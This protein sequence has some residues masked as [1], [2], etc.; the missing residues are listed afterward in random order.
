MKYSSKEKIARYF[1]LFILFVE[2]DI[3]ILILFELSYSFRP[4]VYNTGRILIVLYILDLTVQFLLNPR[5][6]SY[7]L[8]YWHQYASLFSLILL[9][10]RFSAVPESN[11]FLFLYSRLFLGCVEVIIFIKFITRLE[12]IREIWGSFKVNPAQAIIMSFASII[13]LGSFLLY[14]PYSRP[15]GTTMRYIDALFTSTSAVC[16]TGLIVVDTG[17]AFSPVGKTFLLLLIQAGG[18]GIMT[19]AAFI[20]VSTGSEMSLYGR[21]STAALLDQANIRNL[22]TIIKSIVL[23]TFSIEVTGLLLFYPFFVHIID[24]KWKAFFYSVFHAVSAFCNAGF[25]LY[26]DSFMRARSNPWV[27]IILISLI[28]SGGLGF[29]VLI[30]LFRRAV[31]RKKE[32]ITVQTKLVLITSLILILFGAVNIYLLERDALFMEFSHHERFFASL[33]QSVTTRTA[34]FNTVDTSALRPRTLFVMSILMFIGAS[35]GSTGGGIKTTT[36][37]I[38]ILSIITILRDQRF[39]TI[40]KRRIPYAVINRAIAIL[41]SAIGMIIFGTMLL[42]ISEKFSFI[43]IYFETVSAFGTVG[44]STGITPHLS[45]FGKIII[46]VCMFIGRLGP[47]TM[48]LAIRNVQS[49]RLVTY[50]EERVMVG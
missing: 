38:L 27:N 43:Q 31:R 50:P 2:I 12:R 11:R 3:F 5:P 15:S 48:V 8:K 47:L 16:V 25:S 39:N 21:F 6:K 49:P 33:F 37:F 26:S 30:N 36:F 29:T 40:F 20:Q 19:I 24:S 35:P 41:V 23:I 44:L 4:F 42:S 34:G 18:L 45:D 28:V 17:T 9:Y 46:I 10:N 7:F 14:L 32:R 22:Y 13:L 1:D